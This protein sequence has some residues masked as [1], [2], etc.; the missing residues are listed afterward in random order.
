MVF[1]AIYAIDSYYLPCVLFAGTKLTWLTRRVVY[2][3]YP[4]RY[5]KPH[6]VNLCSVGSVFQCKEL[7]LSVN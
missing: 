5:L 7:C 6:F 1:Y 2:Y 4:L 3:G